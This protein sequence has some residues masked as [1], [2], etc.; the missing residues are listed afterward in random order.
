M[1]LSHEPAQGA[2]RELA[3]EL[4]DDVCEQ[5][6]LAHDARFDGKF[7]IGVRTTGIYCRPICR[8]RP[9]QR[10]NI[11]FFATAAAAREA[12][13]RPCLRC[14][15]EAAPGTP[16][17][18]GT[19]ATVSRALRRIDEGALDAGSVDDLAAA[20]GVSSRHLGRLFQEHLGASPWAVAQTRRLHFAKRLIDE[21]NLPM[22]RV[23]AAAGFPSQR[24]FNA[25]VRATWDRTPSEL[26]R[27]Q[28]RAGSNGTVRLRLAYRPPYDW[29]SVLAFLEGR[30]M[31][32]IEEVV[33]GTYRRTIEIGRATGWFA[34]RD[35][36]EGD[37]LDLEIDFPDAHALFAIVERVRGIFDLAADPLQIAAHLGRDPLLRGHLKKHPGVRLPGGWDPFELTVRAI[38]GQQVSVAAATTVA[39]RIV[40]EYGRPIPGDGGNL[41]RLFPRPEVLAEADIA[42]LGMPGKRADAIRTIARAVAEGEIVFDPGM[43]LADFEAMLVAMPGI[44]PWTAQYMAM[45]VLREPDAFPASDLGILMALEENGERPKP[46]A[47]SERAEAWRPWRAYAARLLWASLAD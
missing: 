8:V 10:R 18:S 13:L 28:G 45:R 14:R 1:G 2:F 7:F 27:M 11:D 44:G 9:P 12:G 23:A 39:G 33:A 43:A 47:V 38:V 42:K 35:A 25:A 40:A 29:A 26:R 20:L 37:W 32:G 15:P 30:V 46:R 31:P 41:V 24:R 36:E 3:Q 17:W 6:R 5:A 16:A 22:T 34:V 4:S 19:S 21:T